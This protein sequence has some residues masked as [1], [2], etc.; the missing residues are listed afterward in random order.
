[1]KKIEADEDDNGSLLGIIRD[2]FE[3]TKFYSD[4]R[5]FY[6][7]FCY[8]WFGVVNELVLVI[9][10]NLNNTFYFCEGSNEM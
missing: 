3:C 10:L 1:M 4:W 9:E 5:I 8:N 6:Q 2:S 7:G